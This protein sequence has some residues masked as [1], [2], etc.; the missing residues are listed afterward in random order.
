MD[1]QFFN[2]PLKFVRYAA[3]KPR[4]KL[5]QNRCRSACD[6][7]QRDCQKEPCVT[8]RL[9]LRDC[10][11]NPRQLEVKSRQWVA[12][13]LLPAYLNIENIIRTCS[14]HHFFHARNGS[15]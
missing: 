10:K 7:G 11:L 12:C 3:W 14:S 9:S 13:H 8:K 5:L 1:T 2:S 4:K 6:S 15:N